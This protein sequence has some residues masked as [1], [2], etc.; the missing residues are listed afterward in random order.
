M[1][2][3]EDSLDSLVRSRGPA[4]VGY[5][6]LLCGNRQEAEDLVQD[7]LVK[8]YS[9]G[10]VGTQPDN[11]EGYVRRAVL[12][13]YLDGFRRRRRWEAV[14]H[15]VGPQETGAGPE[16]AVGDRMAVAAALETLTPRERACVVLRYYEDLPVKRIADELSIS[17]G[18][19][20]RYLSDAVR[21]LEAQLGPVAPPRS[22]RGT[23]SVAVLVTPGRRV[24]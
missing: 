20:K 5:A 13:T 23:D 17:E 4:L 12:N 19:V 14:R 1:A 21:C 6:F 18:A 16:Q 9:R 15:L 7:A 2:A 3:W 10:R 24:R 22:R 8:T 11:V